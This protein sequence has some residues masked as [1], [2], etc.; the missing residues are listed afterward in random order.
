MSTTTG[1]AAGS[2]QTAGNAVVAPNLPVGGG[3]IRGIDESFT[4]NPATGS[5][6]FSITLPISAGRRASL[7]ICRCRTT[8]GAG[9]DRSAWGGASACRRSPRRLD[10]HLPLYDDATPD[11]LV[12]SG[13][14]DLV[15]VLE[16]DNTG[17]WQH[18]T[19]A[20]DE[21]DIDLY[22]PRVEGFFGRVERW[23]RRADGDTYWPRSPSTT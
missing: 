18:T 13:Q 5:A 11:V 21:Y 4:A 14:D 12:L 1:G 3:A 19:V 9:T 2:G 17:A 8:A 20:R 23:V 16:P 15:P 7:L 10:R 6:S 22:R